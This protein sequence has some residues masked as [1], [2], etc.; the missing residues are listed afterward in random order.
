[1]VQPARANVHDH[2][3]FLWLGLWHVAQFKF[4]RL[5][6][7]DELKRLHRLYSKTGQGVGQA[8]EINVPAAAV[9]CAAFAMR[10]ESR[11]MPLE[12]GRWEESGRHARANFPSR[13]R[14]QFSATRDR[15]RDGS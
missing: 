14:R 7:L 1:M 9:T 13:W 4:S 15:R 10:E 2:F 6:V 12:P 3:A 5:S 8:I 11:A